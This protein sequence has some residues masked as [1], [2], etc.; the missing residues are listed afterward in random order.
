MYVL[1]TSIYYL[2]EYTIINKMYRCSE[3]ASGNFL[4]EASNFYNFGSILY[5]ED[6]ALKTRLFSTR[7]YKEAN[8]RTRD[9][10]VHL[11]NIWCS[12]IEKRALYS[13]QASS[14]NEM[15]VSREQKSVW[16]NKYLLLFESLQ[17]SWS[18]T[19][20]ICL[21]HYIPADRPRVDCCSIRAAIQIDKYENA[22]TNHSYK[23]K[24]WLTEERERHQHEPRVIL[25]HALVPWGIHIC[26]ISGSDTILHHRS[27][28]STQTI[29]YY[30]L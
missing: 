21:W 20:S 22:N 7:G 25:S 16:I 15:W 10:L 8:I 13:R 11:C 2:K 26:N 5:T 27:I 4:W 14:G 24:V 9:V 30:C 23:S 1:L 12:R 29:L 3:Q 28:F 19:F 6:I 17:A 18:F